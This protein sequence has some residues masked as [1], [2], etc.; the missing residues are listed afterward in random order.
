VRYVTPDLIAAEQQLANNFYTTDQIPD[1][2]N[3]KNVV[4]NL[5]TPSH[6]P[7]ARNTLGSVRPSV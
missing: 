1:K 3:A 6:H 5:L 2:I 7:R 4:D